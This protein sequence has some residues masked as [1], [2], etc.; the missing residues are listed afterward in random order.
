MFLFYQA[1][2]DLLERVLSVGSNPQ[3]SVLVNTPTK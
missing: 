1:N 3:F 2:V